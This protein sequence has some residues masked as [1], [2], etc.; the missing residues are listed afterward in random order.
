MKKKEERVNKMNFT[1]T[2]GASEHHNNEFEH[3]KE[4]I[5]KLCIGDIPFTSVDKPVTLDYKNREVLLLID[6]EVLGSVPFEIIYF[7]IKR[8]Q[9]DVKDYAHAICELISE[10]I[11][12]LTVVK[13]ALA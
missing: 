12:K 2:S 8:K 9:L 3:I 1:H 11:S 4:T 6:G 13:T 5:F 10:E 7:D